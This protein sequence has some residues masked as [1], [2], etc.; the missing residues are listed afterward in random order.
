MIS[1]LYSGLGVFQMKLVWLRRHIC[2]QINVPR[3]LTRVS[4]VVIVAYVRV[5]QGRVR[6]GSSNI[7]FMYYVSR[8]HQSIYPEN[9]NE[10]SLKLNQ[11]YL[12]LSILCVASTVMGI[13]EYKLALG[14][15]CITYLKVLL[16]ME[17]LFHKGKVQLLYI[18]QTIKPKLKISS[19]LSSV[20][21]VFPRYQKKKNP[22]TSWLKR[23]KEMYW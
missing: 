19:L 12:S 15:V 13:T 18:H 17:G 22:N 14:Y 9:S 3:H 20:L 10:L 7:Y 8:L 1:S 6:V 16:L 21:E 2:P 5:R 23:C 11:H 4:Y